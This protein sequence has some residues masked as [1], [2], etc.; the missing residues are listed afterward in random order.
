MQPGLQPTVYGISNCDTVRKARRWLEQQPVDYRFHD[1]REDGVPAAEIRRWL[2]EKGW[3]TV[4]NRRS[5]SG[6]AL[7]PELRDNMN[8]AQ[9]LEQCLATPTLI[10]RPVLVAYR[11]LEF[12]FS[13][14]RYAALLGA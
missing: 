7:A 5:T 4:L 6:R 1:F 13:A 2:G 14:D 11:I 3:E 8:N 12:G 9:A 10:R